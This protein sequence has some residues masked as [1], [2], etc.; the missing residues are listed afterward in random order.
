MDYFK[1]YTYN[2]WLIFIGFL[3][4]GVCF[5]LMFICNLRTE[6]KYK[7]EENKENL[8]TKARLWEDKK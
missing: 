3:T 6:A 2:D 8:L 1:N 4:V 5:I 7:E